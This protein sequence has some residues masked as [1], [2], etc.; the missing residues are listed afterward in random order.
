MKETLPHRNREPEIARAQISFG[1]I[2][3][4]KNRAQVENRRI[5]NENWLVLLDLT[6]G[7]RQRGTRTARVRGII[8]ASSGCAA[9]RP[10]AHPSV[11]C[12]CC[13]KATS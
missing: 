10:F 4:Q 1:Q 11:A 5:G 8:V 3:R 6:V 13:T 12:F 7:I 2:I 9:F